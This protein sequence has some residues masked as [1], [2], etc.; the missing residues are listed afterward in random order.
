MNNRDAMKSRKASYVDEVQFFAPNTL[1]I[2]RA[3]RVSNVAVNV[4]FLP[5]FD[6]DAVRLEKASGGFSSVIEF[7]ANLCLRMAQTAFAGLETPIFIPATEMAAFFASD[8]RP[9]HTDTL[10]S[11]RVQF[12]TAPVECTLTVQPW[13][14]TMSFRSSQT[15]HISF[16]NLVGIAPVGSARLRG[17]ANRGVKVGASFGPPIVFEPL[18]YQADLDAPYSANVR[19]DLAAVAVSASFGNAQATIAF[20]E[21]D[22]QRMHDG[23]PTF[24]ARDFVSMLPS[25]QPLGVPVSLVGRWMDVPAPPVTE[26][27][28]FDVQVFSVGGTPYDALVI[29]INARAGCKGLDDQVQQF[30]GQEDYG[31]ITDEYVIQQVT[32]YS[33]RTGS[34][35]LELSLVAR[36]QFTKNGSPIR[37]QCVRCLS[38]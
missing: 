30:L 28:N 33:H 11:L 3:N 31:V 4:P 18:Y 19:A 9:F 35:P 6:P 32:R 20:P 7:S 26:L 1:P 24:K 5:L 38:F 15:V 10:N 37:R 17:P 23:L 21:V 27:E 2:A 13:P 16:F 29:A 25:S 8:T 22:V 14:V 36:M 34:F 12:Q